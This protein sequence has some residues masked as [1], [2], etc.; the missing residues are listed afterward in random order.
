MLLA[1][2]VL[3]SSFSYIS[4]SCPAESRHIY[5]AVGEGCL[6]FGGVLA[7]L[8][9]GPIVEHLG[10]DVLVYI[11]TGMCLVTVLTAAFLVVDISQDGADK[12]SWREF[13]RPKEI[14]SA[15]ICI[16]KYRTERKRLLL[17]TIC[18]AF[19]FT[20]TAID[21]IMAVSFLYGVKT[22]GMSLTAYSIYTSVI[23]LLKSFGGPA[24]MILAKRLKIEPLY[25]A[26]LIIISLIVGYIVM[27]LRDNLYFFWIGSVL[28][29]P[30]IMPIGVI[31]NEMIKLVSENEYGKIFAFVS[32]MQV[33]LQFIANLIYN[34]LYGWSVAFWPQMFAALCS[35]LYVMTFALIA[36]F[37]LL[38]LKYIKQ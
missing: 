28:L 26:H 25:I 12:I 33:I 31:R 15:I 18:G 29:F 32:L 36:V 21:G 7:G 19:M 8:V 10:L 4:R 16:C 34:G 22:L 17:F 13:F 35:F 24:V 2:K 37:S 11:N 9:T 38:K 1:L 6:L 20:M 23:D 14:F 27:S 3:M 30:Q 5:I